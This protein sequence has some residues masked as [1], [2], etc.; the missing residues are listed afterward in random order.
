M[1]AFRKRPVEIEAIRFMGLVE[2]D[3]DLALS[4]PH[5]QWLREA[6]DDGRLRPDRRGACLW[7]KTLEGTMKASPGDWIVQGVEGELYPCKP[8]I[9]E[10]TYEP[11]EPREQKAA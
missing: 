10:K 5:E 7:V 8:A 9:F 3:L 2:P 11:I 1:S 4:Q 6:L